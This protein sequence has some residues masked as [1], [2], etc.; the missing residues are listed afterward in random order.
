MYNLIY[1]I[2]FCRYLFK[3]FLFANIIYMLF[4]IMSKQYTLCYFNFKLFH[5]KVFGM[6]A[7][8]VFSQIDKVCFK[9]IVKSHYQKIYYNFVTFLKK[10]FFQFLLFSIFLFQCILFFIARCF[11][12][13]FNAYCTFAIIASLY[14]LSCFF[15]F[16]KNHFFS[17]IVF[18][19]IM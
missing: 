13:I 9:L 2:F 10:S 12:C 7:E 17:F 19:L 14:F 18:I 1:F 16:F 8:N 3:K 6:L 11:C 5:I 15:L 4:F